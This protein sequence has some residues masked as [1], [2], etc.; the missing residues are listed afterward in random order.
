MRIWEMSDITT[1]EP[2]D[3][4]MRWAAAM[5]CWSTSAGLGHGA[6]CG[7]TVG[8]GRACPGAFA[9]RISDGQ[10]VIERLAHLEHDQQQQ[11][12]DRQ[13]ERELHEALAALVRRSVTP[14]T[15]TGAAGRSQLWLHA[16][17]VALGEGER[18]LPAGAATDQVHDRARGVR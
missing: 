12:A 1:L 11:Q 4:R 7:A 15:P 17:G 8:E 5:I 9:R 13:D 2:G 10:L 6:R 16:E 3:F 18:G 14:G